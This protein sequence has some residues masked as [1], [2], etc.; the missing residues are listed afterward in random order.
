MRPFFLSLASLPAFKRRV[1][2][3]AFF[4]DDEHSLQSY[5]FI[6][7]LKPEQE[8]V[9]SVFAKMQPQHLRCFLIDSSHFIEIEPGRGAGDIVRESGYVLEIGRAHV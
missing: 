3:L 4:V 7:S 8:G 1:F 2:R 9:I 6:V 5:L